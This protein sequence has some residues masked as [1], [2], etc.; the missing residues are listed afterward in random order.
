MPIGK[1]DDALKQLYFERGEK[2]GDERKEKHLN[3]W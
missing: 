1:R 3:T 2:G